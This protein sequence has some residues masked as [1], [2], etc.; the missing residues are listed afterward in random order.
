MKRCTRCTLENK[1]ARDA[2][3]KVWRH[4]RAHWPNE[5]R[6]LA[7]VVKHIEPLSRDDVEEGTVGKWVVEDHVNHLPP[8]HSLRDQSVGI[9]EARLDRVKHGRGR[10]ELAD[11]DELTPAVVAHELG[12]AFTSW[13]DLRDRKAPT[14]EWASETAADMHATRWGLL[15]REDI[16]RRHEVNVAAESPEGRL[17]HGPPPLVDCEIYGVVYRVNDRFV[18]ERIEQD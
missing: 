1:V 13:D 10:V 3:A 16:M 14:D 15:T 17:H 4:L 2:V 11:N 18:Y 6:F 9:I 7:W 5:A 12:H 8:D